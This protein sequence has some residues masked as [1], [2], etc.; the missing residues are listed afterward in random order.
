MRTS[1]L[2]GPSMREKSTAARTNLIS[3]PNPRTERRGEEQSDRHRRI[4]FMRREDM[5]RKTGSGI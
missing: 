2:S 3:K 5:D 1:V 4:Y